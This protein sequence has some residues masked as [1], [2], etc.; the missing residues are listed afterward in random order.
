MGAAEWAGEKC[1]S[2]L[3]FL[4]VF[5]EVVIYLLWEKNGAWEEGQSPRRQQQ[6]GLFEN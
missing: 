2:H 4:G 3:G 5:N 1:T 6:V